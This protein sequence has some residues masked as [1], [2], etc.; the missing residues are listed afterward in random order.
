MYIYTYMI[1]FTY[2][3]IYIYIIT[4]QETDHGNH[5]ANENMQ[6][7]KTVFLS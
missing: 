4:L 3:F 7:R 5:H 1:I 2:R 6:I